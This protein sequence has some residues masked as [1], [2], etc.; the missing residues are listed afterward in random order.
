[1]HL[2][3]FVCAKG[4]I[5]V[6]ALTYSRACVRMDV[7]HVWDR[8]GHTVSVYDHTDKRLVYPVC[9]PDIGGNAYES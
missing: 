9:P 4:S 3:E 5:F 7:E 6:R 1:M 8:L 2:F